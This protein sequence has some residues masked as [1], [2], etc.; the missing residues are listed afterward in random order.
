MWVLIIRS[1]ANRITKNNTE[2]ILRSR[3]M[4]YLGSQGLAF[5]VSDR[6]QQK[7]RYEMIQKILNLD[8]LPDEE[9]LSSII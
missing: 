3:K 7:H 5:T 8:P 2:R 6:A 4:V 1:D 9:D